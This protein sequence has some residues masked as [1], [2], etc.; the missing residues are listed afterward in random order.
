MGVA[1][2]GEEPVHKLEQMTWHAE[3]RK[4]LDQSVFFHIVK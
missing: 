4:G 3:R 2:T 1:V